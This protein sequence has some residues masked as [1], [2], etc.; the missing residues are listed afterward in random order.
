[1][2]DDAIGVIKVLQ[3]TAKDC[4]LARSDAAERFRT[5]LENCAKVRADLAAMLTRI[6]VDE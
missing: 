5:M 2:V 6:K 1:V 4:P 3:I